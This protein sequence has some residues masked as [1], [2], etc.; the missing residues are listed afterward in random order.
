MVK[1]RL[2]IIIELQF[3]LSCAE[4]LKQIID[5]NYCDIFEKCDKVPIEH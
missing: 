2:I 3:N 1:N 5:R 4:D